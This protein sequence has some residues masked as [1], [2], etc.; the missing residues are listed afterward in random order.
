MFSGKLTLN[1]MR[2]MENEKLK[3]LA[4]YND[5][6]NEYVGIH[7]NPSRNG[8]I[9]IDI[10][11]YTVLRILVGKSKYPLPVIPYGAKP[12]DDITHWLP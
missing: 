10:D 6:K 2:M 4:V 5:A 1:L 9:F 12:V 3:L 8:G 11:D 7:S